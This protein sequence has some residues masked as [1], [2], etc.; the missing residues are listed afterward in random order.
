[1]RAC[2]TCRNARVR[3][4]GARRPRWGR[5]DG[6]AE[7]CAGMRS[8]KRT[9]RPTPTDRRAPLSRS[10]WHT[11]VPHS[12]P[13]GPSNRVV[14]IRA[15]RAVRYTANRRRRT[16]CAHSVYT[17]I[18][19]APERCGGVYTPRSLRARYFFFLPHTL[20]APRS[21]SYTNA[22]DRFFKIV[23][24]LAKSYQRLSVITTLLI[25]TRARPLYY[26][27]YYYFSIL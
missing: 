11:V 20:V 12:L 25:I 17:R 4:T 27:Y 18:R 1:M 9:P 26:Y 16:H 5:G 22:V 15:A 8:V 24:L 3:A 21:R 14:C 7:C 10:T 23:S 13:K 2:Y 6:P 19:A